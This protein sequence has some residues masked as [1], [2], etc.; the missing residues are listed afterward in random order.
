[1]AIKADMRLVMHNIKYKSDAAIR[2]GSA[3]I[4]KTQTGSGGV[5][6][7]INEKATI[8]TNYTGAPASGSKC[9]GVALNEVISTYADTL[10][11]TLLRPT[12]QFVGEPVLIGE[13]VEHGDGQELAPEAQ[14]ATRLLICHERAQHRPHPV[15]RVR[16]DPP[17]QDLRERLDH[18]P[19]LARRGPRIFPVIKYSRMCSRIRAIT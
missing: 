17:A 2:A 1:M 16:V 10:P 19:G 15:Q 14:A 4:F 9:V 12:Q 8:V 11:R 6:Q 3:V 7:G 5:G 18:W 13:I